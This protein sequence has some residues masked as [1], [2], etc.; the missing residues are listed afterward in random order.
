MKNLLIGI[1]V[2]AILAI[3]NTHL[4]SVDATVA[5]VPSNT[6]IMLTNGEVIVVA[7]A[8]MYERGE[9]VLVSQDMIAINY[10]GLPLATQTRYRPIHSS[11]Y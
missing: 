1:A 7:D 10:H 11:S 4:K 5:S 2:I 3:G 8:E 9:K 6:N